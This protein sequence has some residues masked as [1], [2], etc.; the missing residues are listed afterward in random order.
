MKEAENDT[1]NLGK[2][3]N[4]ISDEDENLDDND[5]TVYSIC[6]HL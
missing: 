1:E 2:D 5:E 3:E 6:N 4:D